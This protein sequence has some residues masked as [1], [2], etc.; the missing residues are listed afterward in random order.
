M[1]KACALLL[2][3][4]DN[5]K[6]EIA[7]ETKAELRDLAFSKFAKRNEEIC[8]DILTL[9]KQSDIFLLDTK[10]AKNFN[11]EDEPTLRLALNFKHY[12]HQLKAW[13]RLER[14]LTARRDKALVDLEKLREAVS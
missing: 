4:F 2:S 9:I 13:L 11:I 8:K 3:A 1:R 14:E 5:K 6:T 7:R 12:W 10:L